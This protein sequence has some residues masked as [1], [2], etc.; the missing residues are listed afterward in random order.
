VR[1]VPLISIMALTFDIEIDREEDVM[2]DER[3]E[4]RRRHGLTRP[5]APRPT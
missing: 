4:R 5:Q 2:K 1:L 3:R